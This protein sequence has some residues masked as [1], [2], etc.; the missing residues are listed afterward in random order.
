MCRDLLEWACSTNERQQK[1]G[2]EILIHLIK[3]GEWDDVE[4]KKYAQVS[5][6][7]PTIDSP[8]ADYS[9]HVR[10]AAVRVLMTYIPELLVL[11][12]SALKAA[13]DEGLRSASSGI[14]TRWCSAT[15]FQATLSNDE[16]RDHVLMTVESAHPYGTGSDILER[17]SIPG[18][19]TLTLHFDSRCI[20]EHHQDILSLHESADS[21]VITLQG[22]PLSFSGEEMSKQVGPQEKLQLETDEVWLRFKSDE[23]RSYWGFRIDVTAEFPQPPIGRVVVSSDIADVTVP[24]DVPKCTSLSKGAV[25][26]LLS[27]RLLT[28]A[29]YYN[30][31]FE[32]SHMLFYAT[33]Q[34]RN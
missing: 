14:L 23:F 12:D 1:L 9:L 16:S 17:I 29:S 22:K 15:L 33:L 5:R 28:G 13:D 19:K 21:E 26:G 11:A 4:T 25:C 34:M 10:K 24:D 20:T 27:G 18:A 3:C 8:L 6:R 32:M 7:A 30:S 31:P 2:S